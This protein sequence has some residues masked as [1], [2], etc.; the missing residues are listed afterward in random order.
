MLKKKSFSSGF[1]VLELLVA[2]SVTALL[3]GMLLNITTQVVS[4]Q[5][6]A[7]GDL[8][9]N[10]V[11]QF[12]LDRIQEDLHCAV[13][14]NDGNVWM[15]ATI[16]ED[17]SNSGSW[18]EAKTPKPSNES[19]RIVP[20]DWINGP[21]DP[22]VDANNQFSFAESRFGEGGTFF[23]FFTQAPELDPNSPNT[24]GARAI[25]Y[26]IIRYGLTASSTSRPRY[27]LFRSDV[28]TIETFQAG[29]NL[30]PSSISYNQG[31]N[32]IRKPANIINPIFEGPNGP[33]T[34]FSL[35][36]NIIDFGIRAYLIE[37]NSLGTGNLKQIFPDVNS[38][39]GGGAIPYEFISTNNINYR[40]SGRPSRMYAFP[41]VVD[42][43]IRILTTEGASA[44]SA[45]EEGLIP[46][47]DGFSPEEYWWVL[48][49]KNSE[50]YIRRIKILANG[51]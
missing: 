6:Q 14:R 41:E 36:S 4:T 5:T 21:N 44:I 46:T 1:T 32:G 25:S 12:V 49:E 28:S 18:I 30:H 37:K 27:Q 19:L 29:Y 45:F 35:A 15:A 38:S 51:I 33:S 8:E 3:A 23:R 24:G 16:L 10:Q 31:S 11:A 43:M 48:A 42:V 13:Y 50:I 2:V 34:D 7:S 17:N 40:I 20:S 39:T 26:Q 47:P 9:T 22:F